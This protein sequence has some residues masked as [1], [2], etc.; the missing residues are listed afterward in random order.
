MRSFQRNILNQTKEFKS[1]NFLHGDERN[2]GNFMINWAA[3]IIHLN[4]RHISHIWLVVSKQKVY[5]ETLSSRICNIATDT[6]KVL[7][8][9]IPAIINFTHFLSFPFFLLLLKRQS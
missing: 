4:L 9:N 7:N 8:Q 5:Y 6:T 2:S 3:V 1:H